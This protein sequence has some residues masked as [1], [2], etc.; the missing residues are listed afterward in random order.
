MHKPDLIAGTKLVGG[1]LNWGLKYQHLLKDVVQ[2]PDSKDKLSVQ[3]DD[4]LVF[5]CTSLLEKV[6]V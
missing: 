2:F 3:D 5:S 4:V 1:I 6:C